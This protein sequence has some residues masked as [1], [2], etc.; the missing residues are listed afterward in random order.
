[1]LLRLLRSIGRAEKKNEVRVR[2]SR[3]GGIPFRDFFFHVNGRNHLTCSVAG[4]DLRYWLLPAAEV[5]LG[6]LL[7]K[8]RGDGDA[9]V[10]GG[11]H[12]VARARRGFHLWEVDL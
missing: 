9:R 10:P 11:G 6:G 3:E 1:M 4:K 5:L 2:D 8:L 7:E 12:D